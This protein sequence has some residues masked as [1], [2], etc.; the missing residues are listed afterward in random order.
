EGVDWA[1]IS[2]TI[3]IIRG[4]ADRFHHMKEEDI[5]FDFT[6]REAEVIK[7]FL[8]DHEK[9]RGFVR[10]ISRGLKERK[11]EVVCL[12]LENYRTLL[13]EHIKK[14]D[15]ILF[16]FIDRELSTKQV[17]E[18]FSRFEEVEKNKKDTEPQKYYDFIHA[19]EHR[20]KSSIPGVF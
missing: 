20:F 3:G 16:P 14:E 10:E 19:L 15:E 11:K 4:C 2:D 6:D 18:I 8:Q 9:G 12:N 17:G 5:L 1:C 7:V 13:I